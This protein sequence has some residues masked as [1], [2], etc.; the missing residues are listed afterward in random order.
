MKSFIDC[1]PCFAIVG[2][3][4]FDRI[5]IE[6]FPGNAKVYYA[7]KGSPVINDATKEDALD[8][9]IDK[10]AKIV[11]NGTDIPGTIIEDCSPNFQKLFKDADVIVSKS[12]GNFETLNENER[13]IFFILQIKCAALAC[14]NGF[15][16]ED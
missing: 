3:T 5:L 13:E 10:V 14:R 11:S 7:V 1:I 6:Q 9:S 16:K 2:E 8:V 4:L 12:Q 15:H